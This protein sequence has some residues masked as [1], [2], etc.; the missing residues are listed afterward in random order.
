MVLKA[1]SLIKKGLSSTCRVIL[2]WKTYSGLEEVFEQILTISVGL[3]LWKCAKA[4]V[5]IINGRQ[6]HAIQTICSKLTGFRATVQIQV[7]NEE[8]HIKQNAM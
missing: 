4:T 5:S 8:K 2:I 7:H 1:S 6:T 3:Y